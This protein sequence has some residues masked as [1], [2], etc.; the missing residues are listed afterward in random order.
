M[1]AIF[2]II[3]SLQ[4]KGVEGKLSCPKLIEL[5]MPDTG[6]VLSVFPKGV[7]MILIVVD[8]F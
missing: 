1:Y 7:A 3:S 4:I 6:N 5:L 8:L 2:V